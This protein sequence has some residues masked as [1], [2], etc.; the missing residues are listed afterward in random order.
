MS[1]LRD[2][3]VGVGGFLLLIAGWVG[4]QRA[5]RRLVAGGDPEGD[6]LAGKIGCFGCGCEGECE[7]RRGPASREEKRS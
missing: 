6:G 7:R 3:L 4:V 5:W 1:V 2:Y